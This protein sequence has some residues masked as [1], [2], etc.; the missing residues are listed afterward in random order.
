MAR[1]RSAMGAAG[2]SWLATDRW[3][4]CLGGLSA[5][6]PKVADYPFTTSEPV[7]GVVEVGYESFVLADLPGIIEG[8]H[9]GAGLGHQ[10]L[11]HVERTRI[12]VH[13]L[14]GSPADPVADLDTL[15]RELASYSQELEGKRQQGGV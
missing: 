8:A 9:E 11:R 6:G 10:F 3:A 13:L 4:R 12:L 5:R 1:G 15:N 7:L 2:G 14:D